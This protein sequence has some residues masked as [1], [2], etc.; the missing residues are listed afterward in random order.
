ML[1]A[2][3]KAGAHGGPLLASPRDWALFI[4]ID[5]TLLGVA[6][7][8]DAVT[9]PPGLVAVLDS[10]RRGLGGAVALVTGRRVAD[11]DRLF[12]PL[13][14]VVAGV[15]GTEQRSERGGAIAKLAPPVPPS[16]VQAVNAVSGIAPGIMVE[17][18]GAGLA[19]HYRQAPMARASLIAGLKRILAADAGCDLVLR[20]G[21]MVLEV[22]PR[23]F[24]KGVALASLSG[25][26]PFKGRRPIMIGDD[27]GD[28]SALQAAERLGGLGLT[29][30]GEHFA[31][32]V[33]RVATFADIGSVHAWLTALARRLEREG[34]APRSGLKPYSRSL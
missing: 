12:S 17:Q 5:G 21:R 2:N 33:E 16:L 34:E 6:P 25:L 23:G 11:A 20:P 4:D 22:V 27:A 32:R 9:V 7:T 30:A 26:E 10:V 3:D 24:S 29:V 14:L 28:V 19:V 15:H 31:E 8:P 13:K 1:G 18:K